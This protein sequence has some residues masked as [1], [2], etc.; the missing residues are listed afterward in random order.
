[1]KKLLSTKTMIYSFLLFERENASTKFSDH[2]CVLKK[3][4]SITKS[5]RGEKVLDQKKLSTT[6]GPIC[7]QTNF[8]AKCRQESIKSCNLFHAQDRRLK[9][10]GDV[11]YRHNNPS[12]H[13]N[14]IL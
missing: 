14:Q 5:R 7:L 9:K 8:K 13:A 6:C 3:Q 1:M 12:M 2:Y 4:I 11:I 10:L